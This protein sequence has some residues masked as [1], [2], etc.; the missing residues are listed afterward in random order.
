MTVYSDKPGIEAL[1][2]RR[3]GSALPGIAAVLAGIPATGDIM[4]AAIV[5]VAPI[6]LPTIAAC[7][8]ETFHAFWTRGWDGFPCQIPLGIRMVSYRQARLMH[9]S[10]CGKPPNN[11]RCE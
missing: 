5:S 8:F 6:G 10:P 2:L 11:R 7:G 3:F 9:C 1:V 4:F